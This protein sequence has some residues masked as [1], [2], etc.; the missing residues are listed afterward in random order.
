MQTLIDID[1]TVDG[2]ILSLSEVPD[3]PLPYGRDW[4]QVAT[5]N[6][7]VPTTLSKIDAGTARD[8]MMHGYELMADYL[9]SLG[10]TVQRP[11]LKYFEDLTGTDTQAATTS[12]IGQR[13][14][15]RFGRR[16]DR[17]NRLFWCPFLGGIR[18]LRGCH[19]PP[20]LTSVPS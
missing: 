12:A 16:Q 7:S 8:L 17:L 2:S 1:K 11:G 20:D 9:T 18:R 10:T 5:A 15:G 19:R 13:P 4:T 6:R 14:R 3:G